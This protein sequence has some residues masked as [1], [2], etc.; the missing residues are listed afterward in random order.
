MWFPHPSPQIA[1]VGYQDGIQ[2]QL[3]ISIG[4]PMVYLGYPTNIH[5]SIKFTNLPYSRLSSDSYE[6]DKP[7]L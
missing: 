5:T 4:C 2:V 1:D 7:L 3:Q 6:A